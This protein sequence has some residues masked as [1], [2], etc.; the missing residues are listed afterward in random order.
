MCET[1]DMDRYADEII[2]LRDRLAGLLSAA[3]AV[4]SLDPHTY[5]RD[6]LIFPDEPDVFAF[7]RGSSV[8]EMLRAAIAAAEEK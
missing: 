2:A 1:D 5:P 6:G 8:L 3:K 4:V 7:T